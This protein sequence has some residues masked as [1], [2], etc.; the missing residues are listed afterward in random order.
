MT[1][2]HIKKGIIIAYILP[3]KGTNERRQVISSLNAKKHK[4]VSVIFFRDHAVKQ[5]Q[6]G[7]SF[8]LYQ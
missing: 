7:I 2:I 8:N 6:I 4:P 5:T 1:H 3:P